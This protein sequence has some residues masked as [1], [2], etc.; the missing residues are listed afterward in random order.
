[1]RVGQPVDDN[2]SGLSGS[3]QKRRGLIEFTI[4]GRGGQG[5]VTLAKLIAQMYFL[6]DKHV[7][8]FG[9][10]AAERSGAPLQAYV[11]VDDREITNHNQIHEPDHVIVLDRTLIGSCAVSGIKRDGWLILNTPKPPS[12]FAQTFAGRRVATIDA[13]A[14][15][16]GHGLGT[17]AVPIVN[18]TILGATARVLDLSIEDVVAALSELSFGGVNVTSA[19]QAFDSVT[20]EHLEGNPVVVKRAKRRDHV[21][22]LLDEE[23]GAMPTLKTGSWATRQPLRRRLTPPCNHGCPAGNDIQAFVAETAEGDYASALRVLLETSPLPAVCGRVCPA[24]CMEACNRSGT[25]GAVN[26]RELERFVAE[27]SRRPEPTKPWRNEK[28][29]VVGSGPA[30]LSAAYSL[31]RLGYPVTLF[32]AGRELGGLMRTGIPTYRLPRDVLDREIEYILRHG[33]EVRTGWR[34]RREALLNTTHGFAAAFVA[35]GLQESR[36]LNLGPAAGGSTETIVQG[37]DYLDQIRRGDRNREMDHVVVVGGGNTA[38]DSARSAVRLGA[39]RVRIVY[40][41]TRQEMPAIEEEIAAAIEEGVTIHELAAP[42]RLR[43]EEQGV[44]LTCQR[45]TLGDPDE[46][47][48]PRPIPAKSDDAFFDLPCDRVILALGQSSVLSILPEG[49]EIRE[50]GVLAGLTG[51]PVFCGGDFASKDG[52]VCA[53]IGS[54]RRAALNIHRTLTG[55]DLLSAT[56]DPVAGQQVIMTHLF[57]R[58]PQVEAPTIPMV[59]RRHTFLEVRTGLQAHRESDTAAVEA[60]R[61]FSCG[62]CNQCDR[63]VQYCPEGIVVRDGNEYRF[64]YD[65]CKGCGVCATQCPRGVIFMSEL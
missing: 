45:M 50:G 54:G 18:T 46:S 23:V 32:E 39:A 4:H 59:A 2:Q 35:T 63:C 61:C 48:R 16:I 22:G 37:I 29:A 31:A 53:A 15:A 30:G 20:M 6:Q 13:T 8:A 42:I 55:E 14:I 52:T 1:M 24:P 27:R 49:S 34:L 10:Y 44:L 60:R 40:R 65:Y 17:R 5:G 11:R 19:R 7:Q 25:D 43:D 57:S 9:V 38:I 21:V 62:V 36:S 58:A 28:V 33:V 51:A 26:I 3:T 56:A 12:E 64:D 47:G 41:R